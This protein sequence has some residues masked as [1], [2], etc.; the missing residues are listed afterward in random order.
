MSNYIEILKARAVNL[1]YLEEDKFRT[2]HPTPLQPLDIKIDCNQFVKEIEKFEFKRWGNRYL[3]LPRYGLP[4]VN[5]NGSMD[6][7]I[8]P[9]VGSLSHWNEDFPEMPHME[10]DFT[11]ATPAMR[12][13]SLSPLREF[14]GH[15]TRSNILKWG[16]G[17]E[18]KPHI[19]TTFP[20]L[21][22][23]LW[24]TTDPSTVELGFLNNGEFDIVKDI[25]PGRLYLIDTSIIHVARATGLNYQFFLSLNVNVCS[26]LLNTLLV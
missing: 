21:W 24:G 12:I 18:F 6:N 23:R 17:G 2:I 5:S 4:L 10:T 1:P 9:T 19:D 20:A 7:T 11:V 25:E 22:F 8:E 26:K 16:A 14:D 15:W 13:P 3:E